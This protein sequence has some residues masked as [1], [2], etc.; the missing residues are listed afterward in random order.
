MCIKVKIQILK[1]IFYFQ[2]LIALFF[3]YK[4]CWGSKYADYYALNV[5]FSIKHIRFFSNCKSLTKALWLYPCSSSVWLD[6][7]LG[8]WGIEI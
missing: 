6:S 1:F 2:F 3:K 5:S 8:Q 4:F 7:C